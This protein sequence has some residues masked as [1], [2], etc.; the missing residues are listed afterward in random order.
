MICIYCITLVFQNVL[1]SVP[2]GGHECY[3]G[4]RTMIRYILWRSGD[5]DKGILCASTASKSRVTSGG[6]QVDAVMSKFNK[7]LNGGD[8]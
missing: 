1:R 6:K 3:N 7:S 8:G 4:L 2:I 5:R